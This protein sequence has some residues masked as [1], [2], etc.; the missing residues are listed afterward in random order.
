MLGTGPQGTLC[1]VRLFQKGHGV[2][3]RSDARMLLMVTAMLGFVFAGCGDDDET[4]APTTTE[5]TSS[6]EPT[7]T[8]PVTTTTEPATTTTEPTSPEG[9]ATVDVYV[10]PAEIGDDCSV[11]VPSERDVQGEGDVG[12]TL[13]ELLVGPTAEEQAEGLGSWFSEETAGMLN[14]VVVEDGVAEADF[15]DFSEIIPNASTS[16]GSAQLLAQLDN[17]VLQFPEVEEV[18]YSFDGDRGAFYE[19]LQLTPPE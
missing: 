13:A 18:F 6:T 5:P 15:A 16:C 11:V 1:H 19:W 10:L 4:T 7:T 14:S 12:D 3:M 2:L 17:T 9:S 8:E